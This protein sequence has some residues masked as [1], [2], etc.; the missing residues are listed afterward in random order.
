MYLVVYWTSLGDHKT[1]QTTSSKVKL[2][3]PYPCPYYQTEP[4]PIFSYPSP[5]SVQFT[6]QSNPLSCSESYTSP[7]C[8]TTI[9]SFQPEFIHDVS[10]TVWDILK[11]KIYHCSVWKSNLI[12]CH[13]FFLQTLE[14]LL[15]AIIFNSI[16]IIFRL[17]LNDRAKCFLWCSLISQYD[18]DD[19]YSIHLVDPKLLICFSAKDIF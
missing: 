4:L 10:D 19:N 7:A 1:Y 17:A 3:I 12:E 8:Q 18:S 14:T 2:I 9:I 5:S 15:I 11:L 6:P 13:V 16:N